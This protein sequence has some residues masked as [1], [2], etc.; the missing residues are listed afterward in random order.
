MWDISHP[1]KG[2]DWYCTWGWRVAWPGWQCCWWNQSSWPSLEKAS[3][4]ERGYNRLRDKCKA[5]VQRLRAG[6]VVKISQRKMKKHIYCSIKSK[7]IHL[8]DPK[9]QRINRRTSGKKNSV[10]RRG[11]SLYLS[12][13]RKKMQ[14]WHNI[15]KF[16][17]G[18]TR[19]ARIKRERHL[20]L[21]NVTPILYWPSLSYLNG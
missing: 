15:S 3:D 21:T 12:S 20:I 2:R 10:Q 6:D 14:R 19:R 11:C 8:M 7:Q 9:R 5:A 17:I 1:I 18:I 4:Y 16:L 13:Q